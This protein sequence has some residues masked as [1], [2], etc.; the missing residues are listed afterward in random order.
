MERFKAILALLRLLE[1]LLLV[2]S[3]PLVA[4]YRQIL[5]RLISANNVFCEVVQSPL[6]AVGLVLCNSDLCVTGTISCVQAWRD[7]RIPCSSSLRRQEWGHRDLRVFDHDLAKLYNGYIWLLFGHLVQEVV[8]KRILSEVLNLL[9][10]FQAF[11]IDFD[12][13]QIATGLIFFEF[14]HKTFVLLIL[15]RSYFLSVIIR[16]RQW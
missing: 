12:V 13:G 2:L 5:N 9:I 3:R 14:V 7:K 6:L 10:L 15:L 4:L 1:N 16:L 8:T 11:K